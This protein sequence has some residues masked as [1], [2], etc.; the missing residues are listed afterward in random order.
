[1]N[2]QV[3]IFT[4]VPL[5]SFH[6]KN[7]N[8]RE[9]NQNSFIHYPHEKSI[10]DI[11]HRLFS[12]Q[13]KSS[14]V[15]FQLHCMLKCKTKKF[16]SILNGSVKM[17]KKDFLFSHTRFIIPFKDVFYFSLLFEMQNHLFTLQGLFA[18][19]TVIMIT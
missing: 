8:K 3:L 19:S 11:F 10:F 5:V 9:S 17:C 15:H 18:P 2:I 13:F 1:M 16:S 6:K 4:L 12:Y 7:K 14:S